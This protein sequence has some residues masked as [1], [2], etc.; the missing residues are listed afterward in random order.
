MK[1]MTYHLCTVVVAAIVAAISGWSVAS[2]KVFL[3]VVVIPVGIAVVLICRQ[4]VDVIIEDERVRRI[5]GEAALRTLEISFIL[6]LIAAVV[7]FSYAFGMETA[8]PI[9]SMTGYHDNGRISETVWIYRPGADPLPEN[10]ME[11]ITIPDIESMNK[12]QAMDYHEFWE[13]GL[14]P[15]RETGL[16]GK[17]IVSCLAGLIG[18]Y[19]FFS[20]YYRRKY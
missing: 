9:T 11:T 18:V 20:L 1:R 5:R 3:P 7:M 16:T 10:V 4:H 12:T 15:I 6:G 19:G 8:Q 17:V 14:R 13:R 2:G